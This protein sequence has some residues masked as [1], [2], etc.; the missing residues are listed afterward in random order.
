MSSLPEGY[1]ERKENFPLWD[2]MFGYF[3]DSFLAEVAV[4]VAGNKQHNPGEKLHWA[5]GKSMDQLNT[6]MRHQFDYGQ[7]K[8][9]DVDGCYH[10]AKA[11]WRLKAQ[12]QLDIEEERRNDARGKSEG[13]DRQAA[14]A[15]PAQADLRV[16]ARAERA[17][18]AG[19]GLPRKPPG[20]R[21]RH[22]SKAAR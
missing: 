3:P 2:Y 7:G 16:E 4:A 21:V 17:G 20:V 18:R 5:R 8:K 22:R 12:L 9:K 13:S 14:E 11:I 15:V 10:L 1:T 19:R 6:A